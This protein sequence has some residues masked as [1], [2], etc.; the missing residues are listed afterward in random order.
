MPS[1]K[2]NKKFGGSQYIY[3]PTVASFT[4]PATVTNIEGGSVDLTG[5][6]Y[7]YKY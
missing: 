1:K 4:V 7:C 3:D 5:S 2:K 6:C